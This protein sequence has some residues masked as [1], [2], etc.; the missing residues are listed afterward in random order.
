MIDRYRYRHFNETER[1]NI[2]LSIICA[3][4]TIGIF[5]IDLHIP[6]GVAGGVPYI[7]VILVSLWSPK[8]SFVIYL[9]IIC[10]FMTLLGF[11]LSPAGGELW[12]VIFNRSL[13]LFAIWITA[14]LSLKWKR[15][16]DEIFLLKSQ[17]ENEKE[18]IYLATIHGAQHITNNLLNELKI[19]EY[20]IKNHPDFDKEVS[21]MFNDMLVEA[22]T[23]IKDL[24][25][26]KNI[27]DETIRK[28]VY[29]ESNA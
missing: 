6:L 7:S 29:P 21:S 3:T 22:N 23:L 11:Y 1:L 17:V 28:S 16:E 15:H 12:K 10:S 19:V 4:L 2:K 26:V 20:E 9:A 25:S 8:P 14:I 5:S 24:S 13:A 27:D 18:K